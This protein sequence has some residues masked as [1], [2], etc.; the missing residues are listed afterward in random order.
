MRNKILAFSLLLSLPGYGQAD[1]KGDVQKDLL[2]VGTEYVKV[3]GP[4]NGTPFFPAQSNNGSILYHG[5]L[6]EGIELLYDCEDDVVVIRDLQGQ[7]KL[8]LV[9]EKLEAF[10]VDG[11]RFVKL[12]LLS[13]EGEFYEDLYMGRRRLLVQ[14]QKKKASDQRASNEYA[15]RRSLFVLDGGR[16]V[17]LDRTSDLFEMIPGKKNEARRMYR[18]KRLNFKKGPEAAS[19]ALLREMESKGW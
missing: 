11:R 2:H 17:P 19:L 12:R 15:L 5:N 1:R 13:P 18:E 10:E 9:R 7:L 16:I 3:F 4:E 8:R 6:Y 14:W